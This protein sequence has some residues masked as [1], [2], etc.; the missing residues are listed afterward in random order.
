MKLRMSDEREVELKEPFRNERY[1]YTT[2]QC[3]GG[4]IQ[5]PEEAEMERQGWRRVWSD[6]TME[7]TFSV[8]RRERTQ[9]A[10]I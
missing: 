4:A 10:K 9:G 8:Y 5:P 2:R 3:S 1:Q 6:I 7:G